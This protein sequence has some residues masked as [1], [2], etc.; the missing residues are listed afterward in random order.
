[1]VEKR[2]HCVLNLNDGRHF[3][4]TLIGKAAQCSGE[5]V[6]TTGMVGYTEAITDPS[7]FGQI[8]VFS[9][10]LI[11]NY[12]VPKLDIASNGIIPRGFE[13]AMAQ[14][15]GVI[16]AI[17]SP[18]VFH[19]TSIQS[20]DKWLSDQGVPG[21]IGLDTR[22]LVQ[23]IRGKKNILARIEPEG[24]GTTRTVNR[25]D[26]VTATGGFFDP[27]SINLLPLV[28]RKDR[29]IVGKGKTRL[30][31]VDCG[32]K[33]NIVRQLIEQNCEVE[34]LP[35]DTPLK[36]I[37]C[38]GWVLS[39]GPGDPNYA[40]SII[41]QLKQL[42]Q[43]ER[44]ILGIC[45]GHQLLAKA[46]GAQTHRMDYGHRSHNQPVYRVGTRKAYITS[47]NHGYVV[48]ENTLPSDWEVWFRNANDQ[49]IEGIRHKT[50]AFQ[51][52]Q[53]HPEAAGGPRDTAWII[54]EFVEGCR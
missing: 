26:T 12:G 42:I 21:I 6:F 16:L 39:N 45:L 13:S 47:Q 38:D 7:Y 46:A 2:R 24:A 53:F 14:T 27:S 22:H 51:T 52:A 30:A 50:K 41:E 36:G 20:L 15:A 29:L 19:W 23:E 48:D 35:W 4:G 31:L 44:P 9:Y 17:D 40:S 54:S 28:S 10:P 49:T 32:V 5:L 18:E 11:G 3:S 34:I 43:E 1:M 37:D 25:A 33:W 8:L